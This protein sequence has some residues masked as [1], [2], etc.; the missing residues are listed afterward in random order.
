MDVDDINDE[1]F[2]DDEAVED[3]GYGNEEEEKRAESE[4]SGEDLLDN[5]E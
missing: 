2:S 4:E 3:R 1:K 5:M